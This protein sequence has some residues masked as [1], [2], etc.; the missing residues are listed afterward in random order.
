MADKHFLADATNFLP[1]GCNC[2]ADCA[3]RLPGRPF[4]DRETSTCVN[5]QGDDGDVPKLRPEP[6]MPYGDNGLLSSLRET[7]DATQRCNCDADCKKLH[8][9]CEKGTCVEGMP[10]FRNPDKYAAHAQAN[11]TPG[12]FP[13]GNPYDQWWIYLLVGIAVLF[14][15]LAVVY[16]FKG[17]VKSNTIFTA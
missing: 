17:G 13:Q 14:G 1:A 15:I 2:D 6:D 12:T 9:R 4:C 7:A 3:K 10:V 16:A 5:Q 11:K 8:T